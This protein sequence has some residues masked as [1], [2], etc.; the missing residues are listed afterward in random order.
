MSATIFFRDVLENISNSIYDHL[1][2]ELGARLIF[3][4]AFSYRE[5]LLSCDY[6]KDSCRYYFA[7]YS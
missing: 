6:I 3:I 2:A 4:R 7:S 1:Y 5:M